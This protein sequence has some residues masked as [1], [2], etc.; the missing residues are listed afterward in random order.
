M[1][2]W[3]IG[4]WLSSEWW[5]G[6][7]LLGLVIVTIIGCETSEIKPVNI[8]PEDNCSHCRMAISDQSFASEIITNQTE[9]FKFD[10]IGCMEEFK[11]QESNVKIAATFV[12]EYESKRWIPIEKSFIVKTSIK[13]PMGSG[14]V[15]FADSLKGKALLSQ[16]PL[17]AMAGGNH[18]CCPK[19]SD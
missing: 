16:Y 5:S 7:W 11:R 1:V 14:K 13:T 15:A 19:E 17:T 12:K 8:F 10:D 2:N 6:E 18:S 3:V 4:E 9:V